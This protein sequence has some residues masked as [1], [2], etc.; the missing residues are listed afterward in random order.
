MN[1]QKSLL[2]ISEMLARFRLQVSLLNANA[3]LDV[4][5]LAEDI[6]IP[7]LNIVFDAHLENTRH[8][9]G[10][11][12][13]A[14]DLIDEKKRIAFQISSNNRIQKVRST[15]KKIIKFKLYKDFDNFYIYLISEKEHYKREDIEKDTD[16]LFPFS[17][18]HILDS[19][20]LFKLISA[21]PYSKVAEIEVIL[22]Q[23]FADVHTL[24]RLVSTNLPAIIQQ[25]QRNYDTKFWSTQL[26]S[27]YK[28]RQRWLEKKMFFEEEEAT[29]AD[30]ER[31]FALRKGV[32]QADERLT[33]VET[34]IVK[35]LAQLNY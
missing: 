4:N 22:E 6:M 3:Q 10:R 9:W 27:L 23:Q 17:D 13:P 25:T 19:T 35:V 12:F 16:N 31:L 32:I 11:N 24:N 34:N 29:T 20:D 8:A 26:E 28:A 5:I 14:V 21:L 33:K 1:L 30:S 7:I 18:E 15:L 2:R